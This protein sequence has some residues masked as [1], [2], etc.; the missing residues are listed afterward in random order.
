MTLK[1]YITIFAVIVALV[2]IFLIL[3]VVP[4]THKWMMELYNEN[5]VVQII[6]NI[7]IGIGKGIATFC[8]IITKF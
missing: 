1:D 6:V 7:I 5:L 2:I 3:W 8:K 4:P